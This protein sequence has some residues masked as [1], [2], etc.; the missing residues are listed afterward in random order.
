MTGA[1]SGSLALSAD[2]GVSSSM[3]RDDSHRIIHL[4]HFALAPRASRPGRP[5]A[6]YPGHITALPR[7]PGGRTR[8]SRPLRSGRAGVGERRESELS[9]EHG[10]RTAAHRGQAADVE[11]IDRTPQ[12]VDPGR[13]GETDV[14]AGILHRGANL[15]HVIDAISHRIGQGAYR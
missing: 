10:E 6:S 9:E 2:P 11:P 12:V 5:R 14:V 3:R 8:W 1:G 15:R 13:V 7:S 4:Q